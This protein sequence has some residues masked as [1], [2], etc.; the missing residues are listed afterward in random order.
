MRFVCG[1][2]GDCVGYGSFQHMPGQNDKEL[3]KWLNKHN[4]E[5][6]YEQGYGE[7]CTCCKKHGGK[8]K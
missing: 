5:G 8:R 2:D 7:D 4:M 1:N 6:T 3:L